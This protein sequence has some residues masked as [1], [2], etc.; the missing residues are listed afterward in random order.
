MG[1]GE[2]KAD[3]VDGLLKLGRA[4]FLLRVALVKAD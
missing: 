2:V 1:V 4:I 3:E